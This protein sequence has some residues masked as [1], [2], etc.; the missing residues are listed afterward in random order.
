MLV[1]A[2]VVALLWANVSPDSY[3]SVWETRLAISIGDH[4]LASDL[5]G[6][7]NEGL[8]TLFFLSLIHI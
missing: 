2:V 6:W 3:T 5:R 1:A 7:V 4:T 8:M